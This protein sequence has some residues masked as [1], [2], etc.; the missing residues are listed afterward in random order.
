MNYYPHFLKGACGPKNW[1]LIYILLREKNTKEFCLPM[2]MQWAE[3]MMSYTVAPDAGF[4][5]PSIPWNRNIN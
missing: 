2:G 3:I 5:L 1:K 4:T